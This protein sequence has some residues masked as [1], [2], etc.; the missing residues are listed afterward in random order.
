MVTAFIGVAVALFV[1]LAFVWSTDS[2]LNIGIK[3][4][5][6]AG[7]IWGFVI[8][9]PTLVATAPQAGAIETSVTK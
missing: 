2:F 7:A 3:G 4:L 1:F 6:I 8:L 5:F 9:W